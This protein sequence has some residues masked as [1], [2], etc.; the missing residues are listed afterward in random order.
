MVGTQNWNE[1]GVTPQRNHNFNLSVDMDGIPGSPFFGFGQYSDYYSLLLATWR[2]ECVFFGLNEDGYFVA[3]TPTWYTWMKFYTFKVGL[4]YGHPVISYYGTVTPWF[5]RFIQANHLVL[6]AGFDLLKNTELMRLQYTIHN[7]KWDADVEQY[8]L[9]LFAELWQSSQLDSGT[10][11][12]PGN[13]L[14]EEGLVHNASNNH[15]TVGMGENKAQ[16]GSG[17]EQGN[18]KHPQFNLTGGITG[19]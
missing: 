1:F 13:Q 3:Y 2:D 7:L 9:K 8:W 5:K 19:L 15:G 17:K 11:Y 10:E 18:H 6:D 14:G 4:M 16:E 12:T